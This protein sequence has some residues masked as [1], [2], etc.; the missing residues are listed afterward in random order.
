MSLTFRKSTHKNKKYDVILP[1]GT[2]I[3]FGQLGY[4]HYK[5]TTPLKLYKHLDH[6][7]KDRRQRFR[8]RFAKLYEKNK[9]N[10]Y[11]PMYWSWNYLW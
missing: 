2:I 6:N 11:S 3:S 4:E 10:R 7:D 5:D 9:N 8:S 1:D